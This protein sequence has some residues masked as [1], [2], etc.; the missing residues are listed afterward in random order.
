MHG[1]TGHSANGRA[2]VRQPSRRDRLHA[3]TVMEIKRAARQ[4]LSCE[5]GSGVSLR[6]IARSLG[7]TPAAIY[8]YYPAAESLVDDLRRDLCEELKLVIELA[9]DDGGDDDAA[10]R[11]KQMALAF[12]AWALEHPH[13][14]A[15]LFNPRSHART[16][17][18]DASYEIGCVFLDE[19][20][21]MW[22]RNAIRPAPGILAERPAEFHLDP[23]LT[24]LYPDLSSGLAIAFLRVWATVCGSVMMEVN[25]HVGWLI[26]DHQVFFETGLTNII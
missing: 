18:C 24:V 1:G 11:T 15:L 25:G 17:T 4:L 12:R 13:E 23:K 5:D 6:G 22:R 20:A 19:F 10:A 26:Q 16:G 21:G 8:R 14:F 7:L 9:A 3:E 2:V